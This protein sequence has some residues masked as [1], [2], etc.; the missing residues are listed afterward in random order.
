MSKS[1]PPSSVFF[2]TRINA[3][4]ALQKLDDMVN[5]LAVCL[6]GVA[7]LV[8]YEEMPAE[9][10]IKNIKAVVNRAMEREE[11]EVAKCQQS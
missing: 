9:E 10:K 11:E 3:S 1:H 5:R 8:D 6:A 2:P 7:R 4:S